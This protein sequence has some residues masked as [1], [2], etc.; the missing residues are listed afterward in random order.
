MREELIKQTEITVYVNSFGREAYE[1][2]QLFSN[3]F[4]DKSYD[5]VYFKFGGDF[6]PSHLVTLKQAFDNI[7]LTLLKTKKINIKLLKSTKIYLPE[8]LGIVK[9]INV[10]SS[11]EKHYLMALN[12][13]FDSKIESLSIR[14]KG[15]KS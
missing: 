2:L 8:L 5:E 9:D 1:V 11:C 3:E 6:Y 4:L 10:F 7:N 12:H 13:K 14:L 15:L